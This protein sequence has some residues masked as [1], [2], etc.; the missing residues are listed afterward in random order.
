M[1]KL[2]P[3]L[4]L[5]PLAGC[6]SKSGTSTISSAPPGEDKVVVYCSVDDVYAKPVIAE[7]EKKTGLKISVLY[8]TEAAKTAGL[9]NKIRAEGDHPKGDV[10]WSSA[11]LQTLLL[12]EEGRLQPYASPSAA[13]IPPAFK[14]KCWTAPSVRSRVIVWHTGLPNPPKSYFDLGQPRFKWKI[15]ISNPQFGTASDE[16][17]ALGQFMGRPKAFSWYGAI[18]TNRVRV[19][20]GNSVVAQK[21]RS[22]ELLAGVT[23]TDDFL[24]EKKKGGIEGGNMQM[25]AIP[26]S[27]AILKG[28]KHPEAAQHFVDALLSPEIAA[29]ICKSMP[30]VYPTRPI[31]ATATTK[32]IPAFN[33]KSAP[34]DTS[35]WGPR[36]RALGE[37]VSDLLLTPGPPAP[38]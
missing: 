4:L 36:W 30:G 34:L 25:L 17:A 32:A 9:S 26:G 15:G 2:L 38:R 20:P 19:Q 8:D 37:P 24:V 33:T 14:G 1:R 7:I 18:G 12:E 21:V 23:D 16:V 10:F 28:A 5:L 22:G 3:L 13:T 6:G 11:L 27:V 35:H 29:V 31:P